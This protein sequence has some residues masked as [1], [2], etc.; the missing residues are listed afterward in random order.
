M[1]ERGA[2]ASVAAGAPRSGRGTRG[3]IVLESD[4][5]VWLMRESD[6]EDERELRRLRV[7]RSS[8]AEVDKRSL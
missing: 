2:T 1:R 6:G 5:V 4:E 3:A 8:T 7:G